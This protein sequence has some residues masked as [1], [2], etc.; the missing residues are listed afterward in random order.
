[1]WQADRFSVT[2]E[3]NVRETW[4]ERRLGRQ[5]GPMLKGLTGLRGALLIAMP[6]AF[7]LCSWNLYAV[8]LLGSRCLRGGKAP[9]RPGSEP[10]TAVSVLFQKAILASEAG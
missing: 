10:V 7:L 9:F 1:M 3:Q 2:E 5:T 6:P 4:P 8:Q